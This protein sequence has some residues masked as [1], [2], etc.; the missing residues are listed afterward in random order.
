MRNLLG[1]IFLLI[2]ILAVVGYSRDWFSVSKETA[3]TE[4]EL[5]IQI[6]RQKIRKDTKNATQVA[7]E[8]KDNI[9][10]KIADRDKSEAEMS[11]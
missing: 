8:I 7:R 10:K 6:D 11:Q 3:G 9:E 4:T 5:H 2:I 1:T